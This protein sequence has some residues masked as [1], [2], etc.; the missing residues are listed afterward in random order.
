[1]LDGILQGLGTAMMPI[2][3]FMVVVGCFV[4]TLLG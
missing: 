1:M 4:G 3:L 2:N